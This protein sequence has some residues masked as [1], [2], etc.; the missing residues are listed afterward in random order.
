MR[1]SEEIFLTTQIHNQEIWLFSY[2]TL[3]GLHSSSLGFFLYARLV[4]DSLE[5]T[6]SKLLRIQ[7]SDIFLDKKN[8]GQEINYVSIRLVI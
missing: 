8:V 7:E 1:I 5:N 4:G 6:T 3:N 2:N